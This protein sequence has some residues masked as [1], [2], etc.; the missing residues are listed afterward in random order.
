M[1]YGL[2]PIMEIM[3]ILPAALLAFLPVHRQL[4]IS[5][6]RLVL[7][8][9]PLFFL[10]CTA[11]GMICQYFQ[12]RAAWPL[13]ITALICCTI[14]YALVRMNLWKSTA[15]L[16]SVYSAFLCLRGMGRAFHI[17][18]HPDENGFWFC[19]KA[20][21][22]VHL[23]AL[24]LILM[25]WYPATHTASDLL[26]FDDISMTWHVFW[27]LPA[28]FIFLNYYITPLHPQYMQHGRLLSGYFVLTVFFL[29]LLLLFYY[30]YF[31]LIKGFLKNQ[32]LKQ[33]N[34]FL[35]LQQVKY[36]ALC[37]SI[38]ETRQAR[39]DLRHYIAILSNMADREEWDQVREYLNDASS[40]IPSGTLS[41]CSNS[42]VDGVLSHYHG[43]C[44]Q[45]DIPFH[46]NID[47]PQKLPFDEMF[48]C[49][50]LSNLL[51][52][53]MEASMTTK[54]ERRYIHIDT[55]MHS[56]NV[57]LLT[58]KNT[59][60]GAISEE[61]GVFHSTKKHGKG[62]GTQSVRRIAEKNNG[63]CRYTYQDQI[64]QAEVMLRGEG[65]FSP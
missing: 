9:F 24:C 33:E 50:I 40:A 16:L 49:L 53:A 35:S 1:I 37:T 7:Q 4:R 19:L 52:N 34:Y 23:L 59:Y 8:I 11:A 13:R 44:Q 57:L 28:I 46:A 30:M 45:N 27:L 21:L 62:L 26:T 5:V 3:V 58:V 22:L 65:S 43:L 25:L 42:M 2:R 56:R 39:H 31:L 48:L 60:D 63:Y 38:A 51:E 14:Y 54:Q 15:I 17:Y 20:S 55:Y 18:F 41:L 10:L 29:L 32:K 6:R 47:L 61:N 12:L 36:D 64:F